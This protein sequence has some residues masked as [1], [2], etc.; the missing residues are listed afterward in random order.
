[1]SCVAIYKNN[2]LFSIEVFF[3]KCKY[4][5]DDVQTSKNSSGYLAGNLNSIARN[6]EYTERMVLL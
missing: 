4:D 1:M 3:L 5:V 6:G 2:L